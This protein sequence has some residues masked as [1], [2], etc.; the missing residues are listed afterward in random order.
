MFFFYLSPLVEDIREKH[1]LSNHVNWGSS[2]LKP[3]L[4]DTNVVNLELTLTSQGC[5]SRADSHSGELLVWSLGTLASAMD[6]GPYFYLG[7]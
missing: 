4:V 5:L 7:G 1:K 6:H 2:S 3:S